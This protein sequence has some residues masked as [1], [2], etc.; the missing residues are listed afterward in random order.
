[1]G[2]G[3]NNVGGTGCRDAWVVDGK[4]AVVSLERGVG[5]LI[6]ESLESWLSHNLLILA[7]L[8]KIEVRLVAAIKGRSAIK[9][10]FIL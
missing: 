1:M 4:F 5:I 8:S 3:L 9:P 2:S 10:A 6:V 7:R